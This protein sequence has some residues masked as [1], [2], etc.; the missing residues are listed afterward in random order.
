MNA[1]FQINVGDWKTK[2]A[3]LTR[4]KP[5]SGSDYQKLRQCRWKLIKLARE[6]PACNAYFLSLPNHRSLTSLLGDSSIWVSLV[7]PCPFN[8]GESW[9]AHNAIGVT[10]L[11]LV[12]GQQQLLATLVH[13]FAHINGVDSSGHSAELAALAC[14]FGNW[15]ELLT[16][17]DDP[18]TPYDPSING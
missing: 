16:G 12:S 9:E 14:G 1:N 13:E 18:D 6:R 15:K 5:V 7:E 2:P 3:A 10:A 4:L 8:Y 17:E 11:A